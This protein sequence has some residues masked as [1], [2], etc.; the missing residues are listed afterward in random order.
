MRHAMHWA[1]SHPERVALTKLGWIEARDF[2]DCNVRTDAVVLADVGA[3]MLLG[4]CWGNLKEEP[5]HE[6]MGSWV[7]AAWVNSSS[8]ARTASHD[9][10]SLR[11]VVFPDP[12][13]PTT[14]V[15]VIFRSSSFGVGGEKS[16]IEFLSFLIL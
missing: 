16:L 11:K 6:I 5:H 15:R 8:V 2:G 14:T 4:N 3:L 10:P 13:D 7:Q 9:V 1:L 12:E